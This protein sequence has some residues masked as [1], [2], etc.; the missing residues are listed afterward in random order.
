MKITYN[1]FNT[2]V[3]GLLLIVFLLGIY[4]RIYN[5]SFYKVV[6][7]ALIGC[8]GVYF[9]KKND[10]VTYFKLGIIVLFLGHNTNQYFFIVLTLLLFNTKILKSTS[11]PGRYLYYMLLFGGFSFLINQ[12]IEV[13]LLSFPFFVASF[14]FAASFYFLSH[15]YFT[16]LTKDQII[17]FYI[18]IVL[19]LSITAMIHYL[20]T[21]ATVD[22]LTGGVTNSH[23]LGFHMAVAFL[24]ISSKILSSTSVKS[25]NYSEL[26][27][28]LLVIPV[29]FLSDAKYLMGNM[30][31]AVS[32]VYILF[33][34]QKYLKPIVV[35]SGILLLVLGID[36]V[37]DANIPL[38]I[39]A[40]VDVSLVLDQFRETAKYDLYEKSFMLPYNEPFV[41]LIGSGP[42]TFLS[43]AANSR[44]YDTMEKKSSIGGGQSV[45]IESKLPSF[46]PPHTSWITHKYAVEYFNI[47]WFGTLFDYRSSIISLYWEFGII[48][49]SLFL[50]FFL[51]VITYMN[52]AKERF[53]NLQTDALFLGSFILF[54]LLNSTIAYYFEYPETQILF[55]MLIGMFC[56]KRLV[57][58]VKK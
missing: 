38:S 5:Y 40:S 37:K 53:E 10:Y 23:T 4:F 26:V 19:I 34:T 22:A 35:T 7:P 50:L 27:L 47:V 56:N 52:K 44:A 31:L 41:F 13:N 21:G 16:K 49:F 58:L 46:I 55:W 14:F 42:G 48:G 8:M 9:Y 20:T 2:S 36:Y 1:K 43:R 15:R 6:V 12:V 29:L 24:F 51:S 30:I 33:H 11:Y 28:L 25:L 18:N 45:E 32:L 17:N 3:Y 54:Y 39:K 57:I